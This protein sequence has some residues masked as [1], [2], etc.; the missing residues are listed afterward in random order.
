MQIGRR[1]LQQREVARL[2]G[3]D[4]L[5]G[6]RAVVGQ[7]D[8]DVVRAVDD[9]VVGQDVAVGR[10]DDARAE[11]ALLRRALHA[12]RLAGR[13]AA[14]R[15]DRRRTGASRSSGPAVWPVELRR[16]HPR[17]ALGANRHDRGRRD[18]D[19]VGVRVAA[20]G[21]GVRDR[22]R[23]RRRFCGRRVRMA[24]SAAMR[25]A[26][27]PSRRPPRAGRT[28]AVMECSFMTSLSVLS[29]TAIDSTE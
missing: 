11:R 27:R 24:A 8:L 20:A 9:V 13:A 4:H 3:A 14:R 17:L 16:R 10:D 7:L 25:S 6:Q 12:R 26:G 15:T 5:R 29:I 23:D 2:V 22:R 28:S 19:D 18:V 1:H 21:D